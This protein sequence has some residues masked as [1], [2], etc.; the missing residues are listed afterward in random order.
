MTKGR[1]DM[2]KHRYQSVEA[3][4][5]KVNRVF[6]LGGNLLFVIL[7]IYFLLYRQEVEITPMLLQ[8]NF[9]ALIGFILLNTLVYLKNKA[10][11]AFRFI[12]SVEIILAFIFYSFTTTAGFLGMALIGVL[13]ISLAYYD[14]VFY[15]VLLACCWIVYLSCQMMRWKMGLMIAD[16][17]G[18]CMTIITCAVFVML[19]RI[20]SITKMFS[21]DSLAAI[22][23][24]NAQQ[25]RMMKE[26]LEISQVVK[27]ESD[28][29]GEMVRLLVDSAQRTAMNTEEISQ[30]TDAIAG[31]LETQSQMTKE[32]QGAISE[33]KEH[34]GQMVTV[35]AE[36]DEYIRQN[37][38]MMQELKAQSA[39]IASINQIVTEA[40]KKLEEKTRD[41][42]AFAGV[43]L[44]I[45]SQTNLLAVNASIE[46]ARAGEAGKGFAI[47]AR[48]IRDL[49]EETRESTENITKIVEE[50][51][52]DEREVVESVQI[53]VDAAGK[54]NEMI[55]TTAEL[56]EQL[57]KNMMQ[58]ISSIRVIDQ[59]IENLSE[60]NHAMVE[61]VS[62]ISE[63]TQEVTANAEATSE[64]TEQNLV[65]AQNTRKALDSIQESAAR[66]EKYI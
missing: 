38:E 8:G 15:S 46:S 6:W 25:E 19:M 22:E 37:S 20:S 28:K 43:I 39:Q 3:R 54:Q 42:E 13:G 64:I 35:A 49:A 36:S 27:K 63:N 9:I 60:S 12:I 31:N 26:I 34:S 51:R 7:F 10:S 66:L 62:Q 2:E 1:H 45:S 40:M 50:L 23:E 16:A 61:S 14:K 65:Y 55:L 24:Q 52:K 47:V 48:E 58:L 41:V 53:S 5:A 33:T 29:S 57:G 21:D 18:V 30:T 44:K 32:I 56:F 59:R 17:N 11:N 4:Y